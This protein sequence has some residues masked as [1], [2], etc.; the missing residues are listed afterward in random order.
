MTGYAN[1]FPGEDFE[2]VAL[3]KTFEG[4]IINPATGASSRSFTLAGK[5][6]GIVRQDGK[7]FLLEHKTASQ[8]DSGYLER[9]WTDFQIH[10]YAWYVEKALGW[11]I[12]G[13]V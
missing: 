11:R 1:R 3:E 13:T 5:V 6:D 10:L 4:N 7:Y 2:V 8:I 12:S 9:L